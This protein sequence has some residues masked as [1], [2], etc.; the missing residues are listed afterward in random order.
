MPGSRDTYVRLQSQPEPEDDP[1]DTQTNS[2][3]PF[4]V[5]AQLKGRRK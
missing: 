1:D 5:L 3:N 4:A 2:D